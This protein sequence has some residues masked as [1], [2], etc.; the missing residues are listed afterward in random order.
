MD[1]YGKWAPPSDMTVHQFFG[2]LDGRGAYLVVET[3]N[4]H[5]LAEGPM[6]FTPFFDYEIVPIADVAEAAGWVT[7]A[8]QFRE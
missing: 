8:I 6:K 1:L 5:S 2:R 3:D 7:E 4:P